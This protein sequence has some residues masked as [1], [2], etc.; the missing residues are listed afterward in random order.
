MSDIFPVLDTPIDPI[1]NAPY[2][3]LLVWMSIS[4]R[5]DQGVVDATASIAWLPYRVL[6]DG[7]ID[8]APESMRQSMNIGSVSETAAADPA[9][10]Q[11]IGGI[12]AILQQMLASG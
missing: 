7:T 12:A 4:P 9:M 10:G 1:S 3:G 6:A 5:L 2:T 11:A 8:Q